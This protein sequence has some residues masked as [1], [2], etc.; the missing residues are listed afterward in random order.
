[1]AQTR[2]VASRCR[3]RAKVRARVRVRVRVRVS[4]SPRAGGVEPVV[5]SKVSTLLVRRVTWTRAI[6]RVS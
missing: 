1:M 3:V 5:I 6:V 2:V 4:R